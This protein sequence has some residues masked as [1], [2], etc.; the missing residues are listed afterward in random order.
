MVSLM[1]SGGR[2][3]GARELFRPCLFIKDS[4]PSLPCMCAGYSNK[5]K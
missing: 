5:D 2:G 4:L 3:G 1:R